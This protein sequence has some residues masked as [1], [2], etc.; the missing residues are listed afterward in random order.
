MPKLRKGKHKRDDVV[1]FPIIPIQTIDVKMLGPNGTKFSVEA[2]PDTGCNV[3]NISLATL[4][5]IGYT[6]AD[7]RPLRIEGMT[8]SKL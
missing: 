2:L 1:D 3:S 7:I 6:K 4:K 5:E 8:V